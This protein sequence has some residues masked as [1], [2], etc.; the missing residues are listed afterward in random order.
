MDVGM[1]VLLA[2]VLSFI[3]AGRF[4]CGRIC[5]LGF[6]QDLIFKIPFFKKIQTFKYDK[7][8]RFFK[9]VYVFV[10]H[11]LIGVILLHVFNLGVSI[12]AAVAA[13]IMGA[14]FLA[15]VAI[16]RPYCKFR[17]SG[18]AVGSLFNKFSFHNYKVLQDKCNRCGL[19][20]KACK[21]DIAPYKLEK[22][23]ELLECIRCG[24]CVKACPKNAIISGF[25][26][27]KK[28][29]AADA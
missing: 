25:G 21:M 15:S 6:A 27:K 14:L 7:H 9:Y 2:L 19:C 13:S 12:P 29:P 17:C 16:K 26:V 20:L 24:K 11:L 10:N 5:P 22:M 28:T 8:L 23:P 18:G 4:F 1:I 3:I